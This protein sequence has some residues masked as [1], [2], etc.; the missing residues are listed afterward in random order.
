VET[1]FGELCSDNIK[2]LENYVRNIAQD[3]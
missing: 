3:R 1:L 2:L